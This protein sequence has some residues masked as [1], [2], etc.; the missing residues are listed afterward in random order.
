MLIRHDTFADATYITLL[1]E[2]AKKGVVAR[3][4]QIHPWLLVDYDVHG[5]I[6]GVEVLNASKHPLERLSENLGI[7]K[8]EFIESIKRAEADYQ[9]GRVTKLTSLRV[10]R[11]KKSRVLA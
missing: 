11:P 9:T 8:K 7:Y 3:T 1:P 5:N 10:L 6:F 4:K 2:K